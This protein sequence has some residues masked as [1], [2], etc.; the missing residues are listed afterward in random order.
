MTSIA[1]RVAVVTGGASGI[2][3]GIAEQLIAEGAQVVIA[4]VQQ[5]ALDAT[6]AEIGATGIRVDV[7]DP[8]SVEALA[9]E[10]I[11]RFGSV[12]IVVNNAGI[13]AL[14]RL[15]DLS[16]ADWKWMIDVNLWG[17][18]HGVTTFLP[19]LKANPD[20]GHIVNTGSMASFS[21]MAGG[22]AYAVTK[23]GVAALTEALAIE[24][25]EDGVPVH[26]TLLAPGTVRTNIK[27]S[28]RN[29]PAELAGGLADVDISEGV[30]ADLRW[31][32]PIEAGRIVTRSIRNDDLYALTH[33]D[34]WHI[35]EGRQT[36]IRTAFEKYPVEDAAALSAAPSAAPVV[37][38]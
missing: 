38:S 27:N 4:D 28:T 18:I 2:G 17:V 30:A 9:A 1:G 10:V 24:L 35:V 25:E 23:Y 3:R 8:A 26:V 12:G 13:G 15:A 11:E 19:L 33:P 37:A 32:D 5:D 6:A 14:G 21:P 20:G 36:A 29:R 16:L 31:I 7:T 22:G 34:W